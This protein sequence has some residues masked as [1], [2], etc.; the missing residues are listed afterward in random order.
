MAKDALTCSPYEK[1]ACPT[2][3]AG[4]GE[5]A[6]QF[7]GYDWPDMPKASENTSGLRTLNTTLAVK[8]G[9]APWSHVDVEPG[10]ASPAIAVTEI[11]KK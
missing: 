6:G 9:P 3:D 11:D 8:D 7:G 2:P 4:S 5:M 10:V 1:P